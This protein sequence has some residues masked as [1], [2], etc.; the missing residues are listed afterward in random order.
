M[1]ILGVQTNLFDI[2]LNILFPIRYIIL[3]LESLCPINQILPMFIG[4]TI[5]LIRMSRD[6]FRKMKRIST[7]DP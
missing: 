2:I 6:V 3:T 5:Q 7:C 1:K 4:G